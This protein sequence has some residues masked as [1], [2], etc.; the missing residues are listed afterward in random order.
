VIS[1]S[2]QPATK[3]HRQLAVSP[4]SHTCHDPRNNTSETTGSLSCRGGW[5]LRGGPPM[6]NVLG[7][8]PGVGVMAKGP[9]G[10]VRCEDRLPYYKGNSCRLPRPR[11]HDP[12]TP[13]LA[14]TSAGAPGV[15]CPLEWGSWVLG[16]QCS[17]RA[18]FQTASR[19]NDTHRIFG[20]N[21]A[22]STLNCSYG[23]GCKVCLIFAA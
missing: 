23:R 19:S 17:A 13:R 9:Q 5:E 2:Q 6:Q 12:T 18:L 11:G 4:N 8:V 21:K 1:H 14:R 15:Q 10:W 7:P 20:L 22:L 3:T 16:I